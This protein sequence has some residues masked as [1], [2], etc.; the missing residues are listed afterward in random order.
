MRIDKS[1]T[2]S[3][4]RRFRYTLWRTWAAV[5]GHADCYAMFVGLNPSTADEAN[6]DP[7]IRRCVG[8]ARAWGFQGLCMTNLFAYRAT[9]PA[10]MLAQAD[11]V[12]EGNDRTLRAMAERAGIVVA[13][14]GVH[15]AH[16]G[17]AAAVR[18]LLPKLH[19]LKLTKDGH[20]AHP[21]YLPKTLRPLQSCGASAAS[22]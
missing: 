17:R 2:F 3:P 16:G 15:G 7:T 1:A 22:Q 14:W 6:D 20:P 8:F 4:C 12:G 19:Y 5:D 21:L 18:K 11:P 13:A 9:D 10:D